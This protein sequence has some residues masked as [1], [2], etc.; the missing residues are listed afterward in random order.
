MRRTR[1]NENERMRKR[2]RGDEPDSDKALA[3]RT[4]GTS[5]R[6]R[7]YRPV[8]RPAGVHGVEDSSPRASDNS[9]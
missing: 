7:F 6:K 2:G 5:G 1:M 4:V 3:T 8:K 9:A